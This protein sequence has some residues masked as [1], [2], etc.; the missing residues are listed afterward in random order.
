M[1]CTLGLILI[2]K[3]DVA[4]Q[5]LDAYREEQLPTGL[6]IWWIDRPGCPVVS[7]RWV[8][9]AGSRFDPDTLAG[10][11]VITASALLDGPRG[12]TPSRFLEEFEGRGA[13][14][15]G[16][17]DGDAAVL[18]LDAPAGPA[19]TL[20]V[21][22]ARAVV[23]PALSGA[24][25]EGVLGEAQARSAESPSAAAGLADAGVMRQV[26]AGT[27]YAANGWGTAAT[28]GRLTPARLREFHAARY[29]P[30]DSRLIIVGPLAF[31]RL[32]RGVSAVIQAAR[33]GGTAGAASGAPA[34]SG[35][36]PAPRREST[37]AAPGSSEASPAAAPVLLLDAP[38]SDLAAI[39]VALSA[40]ARTDTA[41]APDLA[42]ASIL[43]GDSPLSL[44]LRRLRTEGG[45]AYDARG[46]FVQ[47]DLV[48][49]WIGETEV[50]VP[51]TRA[52]IDALLAAVD[53]VLEGGMSLEDFTA[54]R[55][56]WIGRRDLDLES[57]SRAADSLVPVALAGASPADWRGLR[58]RLPWLDVVTWQ[59][60][61][62]ARL[63]RSRRVI[64]VAAPVDRVLPELSGLGRVRVARAPE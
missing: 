49:C 7:A 53:G 44:L 8:F 51:R 43:L 27:P 11:A 1:C 48:G 26:N 55:V 60:R 63:D 13:I 54:A 16:A 25:L 35:A 46:R 24:S 41:A 23:D 57:P 4:A 15:S 6:T 10:L 42:L 29:R 40:P 31:D 30:E 21:A 2:L 3:V 9:H 39:R 61:M 34:L 14:L 19:D 38:G 28:R 58:D 22:L 20:L 64:V 56:Y 47:R 12:S 32:V 36:A 33:Q 52:A 18:R 45:L 62:R 17:V 59:S 50:P 5:V 37:G